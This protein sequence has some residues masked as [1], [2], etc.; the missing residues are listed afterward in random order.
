MV[1]ENAV[2]SNDAKKSSTAWF[3]PKCISMPVAR[4]VPRP[5]RRN[6]MPKRKSPM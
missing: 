2:G 6:E 4:S 1:V 3:S 5:R